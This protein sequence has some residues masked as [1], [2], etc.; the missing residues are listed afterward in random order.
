MTVEIQNP[1]IVDY[2]G[3]PVMPKEQAEC[4]WCNKVLDKDKMTKTKQY[5]VTVYI[6]RGCGG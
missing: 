5:G 3:L 6:C 1:K 4:Y 2:S